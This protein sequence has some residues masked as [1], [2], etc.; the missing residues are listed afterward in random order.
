MVSILAIIINSLS[1]QFY[2]SFSN[3]NYGSVIGGGH[4][5]EGK[6]GL[7]SRKYVV[8]EESFV[9]MGVSSQHIGNRK[10]LCIKWDNPFCVKLDV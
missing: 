9:D 6:K 8:R 3:I 4:M 10:S 1:K 2:R 5:L 7:F